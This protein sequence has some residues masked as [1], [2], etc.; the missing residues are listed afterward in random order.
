MIFH[1]YFQFFAQLTHLTTQLRVNVIP[2]LRREDTQQMVGLVSIAAG[3]ASAMMTAGDAVFYGA[4][5]GSIT[6][7]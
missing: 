5:F 7:D 2:A 1:L 4:S 6:W 3:S